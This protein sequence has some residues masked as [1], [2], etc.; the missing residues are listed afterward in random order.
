MSESADS[1]R[2]CGICLSQFSEPKILPCFHSF[3]LKCLE[4]NV[5]VTSQRER[6]ACP[7][8]RTST[9][10]PEIGVKGFQTNFYVSTKDAKADGSDFDCDACGNSRAARHECRE[11]QQNFCE[12]CS[13]VHL[14]MSSSRQHNLTLLPATEN[15]RINKH[16]A[17]THC[18]KHP[19]EELSAVCL[20]CNDLICQACKDSAH[21]DHSCVAISA[22][23]QAKRQK[24]KEIIDLSENNLREFESDIRVFK[25]Q[26]DA[27]H[28]FFHDQMTSLGKD[29]DALISKINERF[30]IF[31]MQIKTLNDEQKALSNEVIEKQFL[32]TTN[33]KLTVDRSKEVADA[34]EDI[35]VLRKFSEV[36]EKL[37]EI[38]MELTP[39]VSG[40]NL[41]GKVEECT[42]WLIKLNEEINKI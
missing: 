6:F 27:K 38:K 18:P 5:R 14:R 24:L 33:M 42:S 12:Q 23:A 8:C 31:E 13:N 10:I 26:T 3:C 22:H 37:D 17:E 7:T 4:N 29:K 25:R 19:D 15:R 21:G 40:H 20:D 36:S 28:R 32:K 35:Y 41:M 34:V 1:Q 9:A 11:C 39:A 30:K 2:V 16:Q